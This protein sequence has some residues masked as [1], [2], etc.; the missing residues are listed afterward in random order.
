MTRQSNAFPSEYRDP[1]QI[2]RKNNAYRKRT[3]KLVIIAIVL[4]LL[5]NHIRDDNFS[6]IPVKQRPRVGLGLMVVGLLITVKAC[7]LLG[8]YLTNTIVMQK[9]F[10][11]VW[12]S[13]LD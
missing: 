6:F 9:E 13:R 11:R 5:G 10:G 1:L 4:V 3:R 2:K 12:I 8:K 7:Y